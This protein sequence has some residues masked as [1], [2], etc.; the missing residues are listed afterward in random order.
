MRDLILVC[1]IDDI[2]DRI[3]IIELSIFILTSYHLGD[4]M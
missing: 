4:I 1:K 3:G 2:D